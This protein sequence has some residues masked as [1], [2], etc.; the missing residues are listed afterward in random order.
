M[1]KSLF[2]NLHEQSGDLWSSITLICDGKPFISTEI[3][4]WLVITYLLKCCHKMASHYSVMETITFTLS[5]VMADH[6]N[7]KTLPYF[8]FEQPIETVE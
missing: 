1:F 7:A 8:S 5:S 2:C 4:V 6:N 3:Q